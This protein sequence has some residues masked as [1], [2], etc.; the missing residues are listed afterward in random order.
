MVALPI[1]VDEM[2]TDTQP[3]NHDDCFD[4]QAQKDYTDADC[5]NQLDKGIAPLGFIEAHGLPEPR[6]GGLDDGQGQLVGAEPVEEHDG[7]EQ[8]VHD[9]PQEVSDGAVTI[10]GMNR[11]RAEG[12]ETVE[13]EPE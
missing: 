13:Q 7:R 4:Q 2:G 12:D 1:F 9:A 5:D 10:G 11:P 3:A 6:E 8:P